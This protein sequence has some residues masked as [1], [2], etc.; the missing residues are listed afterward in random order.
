MALAGAHALCAERPFF[1]RRHRREPGRAAAPAG[2]HL[3]PRAPARPHDQH[4]HRAAGDGPHGLGRPPL[5]QQLA[6]QV[7]QRY[8]TRLLEIYGSTETGQIAVRRP[9]HSAEWQLWPGSRFF[10]RDGDTWA[11]GGHIEQ[12]TCACAMCW[13][14]S[15]RVAS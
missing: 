3:D 9:T 11:E 1:P 10:V 15:G 6:A 4:R 12:P 2:A 5:S 8:D 14:A 7:E 13:K